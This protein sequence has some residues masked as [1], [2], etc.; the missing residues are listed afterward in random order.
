MFNNVKVDPSVF[1]MT[2]TEEMPILN[3]NISGDYTTEKLKEYSEI[4]QKEIESL[5]E[6]KKVDIRGAL[7]KEVEIAVDIYKMMASKVSFY[8]IIN[9]VQS[10]NVSISAG[11]LKANEER[12]TIRIIGE[13]DSPLELENFV[14]KSSYNNSVFLKDIAEITFKEKET[15]TYAREN[16]KAV[17]MLDVK[18]R[19]G[20]NTIEAA[21]KIQLIVEKTQKNIFPKN[22]IVSIT[23][24]QSELTEN[25]VIDLVNSIIFGVVLVV[26]VL[27][28][29]LG[30]KNA[31]FVGIAIPMSMFM[32]IAIL[33]AMGNTLNTMILFGLI[34]GLGMLVDNGIVVVENVY[35]LMEKEGMDRIEATKK[36][37]SEI[38]FPI[39]ISTATTVAAFIPLGL[40]PGRIGKF[41]IF[42]PVTLSVVLCSSLIVAI[43]FNSVLVSNLMKI[44]DTNMPLKRIIRLTSLLGIFG[45]LF[46]VL[47]LTV[48]DLESAQFYRF[49]GSIQIFVAINFWIYRLVLR[50]LANDFQSK[51]LPILDSYY[52]KLLKT[53][54][55]GKRPY[56]I[57]LSTF[58]SLILAFMS[59][60][61]SVS[62][63][64]TSIEF[65]PDEDP[66]QIIVYVQ[67]P[68]G[69][70]I[71]KTNEIA[72]LIES[73][74]NKIIYDKKY[75]DE[76]GYNFMIQN[77]VSQVGEGSENPEK[78]LGALSEM[79]N[80][81]KITTSFRDFKYRREFSSREVR[82]EIQEI[83]KDKYPGVSIAVEKN[84]S[85]PPVGYPINI[86]ITGKDYT[87][88]IE[89]AEKITEY[90]NTRNIPG[91]EELKIDVNKSRVINLVNID[92]EKSGEL[93]LSVGQVGQQ[94]RAALFGTKAGIYKENGEDYDINIRFNKDNR[95]SENILFDQ[96][97][98]FRDPNNGMI[99]EI[100]I[101]SVASSSRSTTF[102]EI[103]HKDFK[104]IVTIYSGLSSGY[105]DAGAVV[106]QIVNEMKNFKEDVSMIEID[107]TG[108][109]EEQNKNQEFLM[110]A[111][112]TGLLLIFLLL[113]LQFNSISKPTIIMI[114]IILSL[115]GVFGYLALTGN[116][117]VILMTMMGIIALSGIVVN[118]GV[119]LLD[120]S[121]ILLNRKK[122]DKANK[123][124]K[125]IELKYE[126]I[127]ESCK[128]RLRP[129][130]LTA[131]TTI[132]G[133][134]PLA[135][136]FNINFY[137]LFSDLNP[138]IYWGGDNFVFWGPLAV[139]VISGLVV[140]TFLT[141]F[142]VPSLF[143][144]IEKFKLW[145]GLRYR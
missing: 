41:M 66:R 92:R 62:S 121:V 94:L 139:T 32:S 87:T 127:V 50:K 100:P 55:I 48:K 115:I 35:R 109:I 95:Y 101:S 10:G 60:G 81:A 113:I 135:A 90:I 72:K 25:Q 86:E 144:M 93:G 44:E 74:I 21:E 142:V 56:L 107:Y 145:I 37:I 34:L 83:L 26:I 12:K 97:L 111:F 3:I 120:Y 58:I 42:F 1:N 84:S 39:I 27:L 29:F 53:I 57:I 11:N 125:L 30:F 22:L 88:L 68:E 110:K 69:T 8:D 67:Y 46:L 14:V 126:S 20:E 16:G 70:D 89:K 28:F 17:V 2:F 23:N 77:N 52:E 31:L 141:L 45:A 129:V 98:T 43:F 36:G 49:L 71:S 9:S 65:F 105:V 133:L 103:K 143:M 38:A 112:L 19:S 85:G 5:S 114:A 15:T 76:S 79:P 75:Y 40:W 124:K 117:F 128:S 119:V 51:V 13:I 116:S 6:I 33:A 138:N 7:E 73:D 140:A 131:I 132:G 134:I 4:L 108:Q 64:R 130:L 118:N 24:D 80:R 137:T 96:N 61:K 91:I 82:K 104:R 136:G 106:N 18:K 47:G 63:Q 78:E 102:S 59:F 122:E 123:D 54:L 99:K